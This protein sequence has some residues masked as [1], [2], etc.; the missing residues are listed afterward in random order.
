MTAKPKLP[1]DA[2]E[3]KRRF[4]AFLTSQETYKRL[5]FAIGTIVFLTGSLVGG[6]KL[7]MYFQKETMTATAM[8]PT[9]DEL[10]MDRLNI[11]E[12]DIIG[13]RQSSMARATIVDSM[14]ADVESIKTDVRDIRRM[15][16]DLLRLIQPGIRQ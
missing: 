15:Q 6:F 4:M 11:L 8:L 12:T 7:G 5:R 14:R 3:N 2:Y 16:M 10:P 9:A 1:L 13:L